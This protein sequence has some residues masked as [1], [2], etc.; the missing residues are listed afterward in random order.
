MLFPN[1]AVSS[2]LLIRFKVPSRFATKNQTDVVP[3]YSYVQSNEMYL[4]MTNAE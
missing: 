1:P 3:L 4:A 2:K